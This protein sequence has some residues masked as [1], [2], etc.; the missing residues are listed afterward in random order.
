[1]AAAS[2]AGSP[3]P[4]PPQPAG[5]LLRRRENVREFRLSFRQ[6]AP[7]PSMKRQR[8]SQQASTCVR[9][10]EKPD[11]APQLP[12]GQAARPH[13]TSPAWGWRFLP[14]KARAGDWPRTFLR[15]TRPGLLARATAWSPSEKG[16]N[17]TPR[18][19][20]RGRLLPNRQVCDKHQWCRLQTPDSRLQAPALQTPDSSWRLRV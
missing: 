12:R 14:G 3:D 4:P 13:G 17:A 9:R 11:A 2:N 19:S 5:G 10:A 16:R 8:C 15:D 18:V 20:R 6:R 1:M 7:P